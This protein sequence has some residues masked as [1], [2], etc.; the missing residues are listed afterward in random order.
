MSLLHII[1]P[2]VFLLTC[3]RLYG[4]APVVGGENRLWKLKWVPSC[5]PSEPM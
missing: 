5:F 4:Y 2:G 3:L 1:V